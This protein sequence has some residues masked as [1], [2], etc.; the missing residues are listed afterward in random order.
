VPVSDAVRAAG[1]LLGID[2]LHVANEGKAVIAVRAEA[3]EAVLTALRVHP[4]GR[5]AA[6][7]G[8]AMAAR[9]G[10]VVLDTG[11]GHRLLAE[12]DGE[13]LPRIC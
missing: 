4:L 12:P 13:L 8:T 7:V 2:P 10:R 6:I 11:F 9:A 3:A 5:Q 1:E